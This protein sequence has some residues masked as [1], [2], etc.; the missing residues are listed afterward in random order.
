[1]AKNNKA[2]TNLLS[3]LQLTD[4][5]SI[6]F[7]NEKKDNFM[8]KNISKETLK[9][10]EIIQ[11]DAYYIFNNQPYILFFDL[12][13][14][15]SF[16][17]EKE[18]HKQ[19]WSFDQSPIIF[20]IKD[21]DITIYNAFAYNKKQS[22]L[23]KIDISAEER[24]KQFSFWNLQSGNTWKWLQD[25]YYKSRRLKDDIQSKRVN[26]KLFEN[27]K[28]VREELINDKTGNKLSED[29]ANILIL[30]LIFIRYLIDR[31]VQLSEEPTDGSKILHSV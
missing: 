19:V 22:S 24:T 27:I 23:Q 29:D 3:Q 26:Q 25:N 31:D 11:P 5:E 21:G 2:L 14:N 16:E 13:G 6:F 9:K 28:L 17:K 10:L 30:R 20:I 4:S 12:T 18:I 15:F 1:M 8:L 7:F